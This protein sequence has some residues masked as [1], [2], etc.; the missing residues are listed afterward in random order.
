MVS[1]FQSTLPFAE[2]TDPINP[3]LRFSCCLRQ[4]NHTTAAHAINGGPIGI[5]RHNPR[6]AACPAL[7]PLHRLPGAGVV[8]GGDGRGHG[9]ACSAPA[10]GH[11]AHL[12]QLGRRALGGL[13]PFSHHRFG[14]WRPVGIGPPHAGVPAVPVACAAAMGRSTRLAPHARAACWRRPAAHRAAGHAGA[15]ALSSQGAAGA[16]VNRTDLT[17][18]RLPC[19]GAP[20]VIRTLAPLTHSPAYGPTRFSL[21]P[22]R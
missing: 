3:F 7:R 4:R 2:E 8:R 6:H 20:S 9:S 22:F 19:G 11:G 10:S 18:S 13:S 16:D 1:S 21:E 5:A 17:E 12:Q 15:R 14:C